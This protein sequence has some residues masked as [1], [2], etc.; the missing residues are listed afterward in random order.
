MAPKNAR[1]KVLAA[2][3]AGKATKASGER[4][5]LDQA[6][7]CFID[8]AEQEPD[9]SDIA[10]ATES[11]LKWKHG[12]GKHLRSVYT[13]DSRTTLWRKKK[14]KA[15]KLASVANVPKISSFFTRVSPQQDE[16]QNAVFAD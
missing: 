11:L 1:W 12:A 3:R 2:A 9:V 5:A 14:E 8:D 16:E 10:D 7:V 15:A 4:T 13:K 6:E